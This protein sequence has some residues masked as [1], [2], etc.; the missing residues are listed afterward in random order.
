MA[1]NKSI[2]RQVTERLTAMTAFGQSKHMDKAVNGGKPDIGKVYSHSTLKNYIDAGSRFARWVRSEHG[3][4]NLDDARK[5][6]GE[7]LQHRIDEG[8]SAWTVRRDAAALGKL[9]QCPTTDLGAD[10]PTR[11]RNEVT[12]HRGDRSNG[13]FSASRHADLVDLCRATGLRRHE[14]AALVPDDVYRD[15][16][17]RT[18][19]HVRQGK[20]GKERTVIALN[21]APLR[22]AQTARSAGLSRVIAHIPKY[23]PIHQLRGEFA[24]SL[25]N[26]LERPVEALSRSER[27][28]CRGDLAGNIYDKKAMQ[29]VSEALG[30][31]RLGVV[32][33]YL[34]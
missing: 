15:A 8:M 14:V 32:T 3:C 13:H 6:T 29:A 1:K 24:R 12:Q 22:V 16:D 17:G 19:V 28:E 4:K 34:R 9:Y 18:C 2:V 30:H 21:D 27:Y 25:Y 5:F 11:H 7:Y 26:R 10:L 20:G 31:S 33:A 23:A